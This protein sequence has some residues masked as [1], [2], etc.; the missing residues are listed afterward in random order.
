M[1]PVRSSEKPTNAT[2]KNKVSH[3][4]RPLLCIIFANKVS[5]LGEVVENLLICASVLSFTCM[6]MYGFILKQV[7]MLNWLIKIVGKKITYVDVS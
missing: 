2:L 1:K 7:F 5:F 3:C 6:H 4:N